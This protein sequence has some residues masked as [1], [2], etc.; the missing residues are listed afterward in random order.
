MPVSSDDDGRN[1]FTQPSF[2]AP[3]KLSLV[4]AG[5]VTFLFSKVNRTSL[6]YLSFSPHMIHV[7]NRELK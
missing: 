6:L 2:H 7:E 4:S 1:G 5:L 3:W